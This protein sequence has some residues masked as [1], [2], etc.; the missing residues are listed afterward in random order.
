MR[1]LAVALGAEAIRRSTT[2]AGITWSRRMVARRAV[3]D[4]SSE[5]GIMTQDRNRVDNAKVSLG[6]R[7]PVWWDGGGSN[8][9]RRLINNTPYADGLKV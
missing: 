5:P 9:N 1:A 6:D 3:R 2:G 8:L 4:S 7:G